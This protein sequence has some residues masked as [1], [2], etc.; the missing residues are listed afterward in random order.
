MYVCFGVCCA[1]DVVLQPDVESVMGYSMRTLDFRY[2]LWLRY[3]STSCRL[4][5]APAAASTAAA[6]GKKGDAAKLVLVRHELYA[7][8]RRGGALGLDPL[9]PHMEMENLL[10]R[11]AGRNDSNA[12]V[13]AQARRFLLRFLDQGTR[14]FRFRCPD[15]R[16]QS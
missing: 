4:Q 13:A 14:F 16:L 2:I 15:S 1:C 7:H 11:A 9:A 6:R 3:N 10:A 8:E 5:R 12:Q